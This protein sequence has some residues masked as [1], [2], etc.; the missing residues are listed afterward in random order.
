MDSASAD[1]GGGSDLLLHVFPGP[2]DL[3]RLCREREWSQ[4]PLGPVEQWPQSLRTA[5]STVIS[6][7]FPMMLAWGPELVQIY[8][9]GYRG[10]MGSKHPD[11]LGQRVSECWT[12]VWDEIRPMFERVFAGEVVQMDDLPLTIER[13]GVPEQTYFTFAYSPVR[14]ES[15][16]VGGVLDVVFETTEQVE[17]RRLEAERQRL[18]EE[19]EL[20]RARLEFAFQRAPSFF[21]VLRGPE[22][23]FD[24]VNDAYYQLVGDRDLEGRPLLEALPEMRGQGF[25]ELLDEVVRSGER[26]VGRETPVLLARRPGSPPEER[27]VDL[28]YLP[29]IESGGATTGVIA[30][31]S[32]VTEH[33]LSRRRVE[34]LL[35]ESEEARADAETARAEAEEANRAKTDF[36]SAMSHELRTPLNAIGGYAELLDIGVHGPV[37][38]A[39]STAL[40]RIAISQRHLLALIQDILSYARLEVGRLEFHPRPLPAA[41]LLEQVEPLI[42]VQ[43]EAKGISISVEPCAPDLRLIA[44]EERA[45]QILLNLATNAVKFTDPGGRVALLCAADAEWVHLRVQDS[46]RGISD[47]DQTRIFDAFRQVGRAADRPQEGIGLGLAISRDLASAMA[48]DLSVESTLG[49]GSTFTLRLPRDGTPKGPES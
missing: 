7:P 34:Q 20:E 31:G 47:E 26:W 17:G 28:T 11:G 6:A 14:D 29:L 43:A 35:R 4:T 8:N 48:G 45:R 22:Y 18:Y 24:R 5:A 32:D 9:D 23:T 40:G 19:L 3:A 1:P 10:I 44:D 16:G 36:L 30:H 27:F 46:G 12:E 33:V 21:A 42:Q 25:L 2:S 49:E 38:D 41:S 39:Q 15:G 37:T 13:H